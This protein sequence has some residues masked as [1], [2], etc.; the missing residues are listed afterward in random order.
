MLPDDQGAEVADRQADLVPVL[1][2]VAVALDGADDA[3]PSPT[4]A[5]TD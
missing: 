1:E 4:L 5:G 3:D 2:L